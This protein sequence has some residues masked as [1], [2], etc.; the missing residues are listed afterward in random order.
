ME[1]LKES[2]EQTKSMLEQA[3]SNED[4]EVECVYN[5]NFISKINYD[6]VNNYLRK[7]KAYKLIDSNKSS[8]DISLL[9]T[10]YR[11]TVSDKESITE[12]CENNILHF[13]E[14]QKKAKLSAFVPVINKEYDFSIKIKRE[15]SV[16][17]SEIPDFDS[18]FTNRYKHY[19]LK[20]RDSFVD[21]S[22]T[23][24]IDLTV[25]KQSTKV[26]QTI[27]TSG[28]EH[29][30]EKYEI[31][32]EFLNNSNNSK[33]TKTDD[34]TLQL[35]YH[36][37][38]IKK[39]MEDSEYL[40][41]K[42]NKLIVLNKYINLV[43]PTMFDNHQEDII[44]HIRKVVLKRPKEHMLSYQPITLEQM[45]I[46]EE[47]LGRKSIL[48]NYTVTEK[49]DGERYLIF[50][51]DKHDMFSIDSRLSVKKL[52]VKH[53]LKNILVDAEFVVKSKFNTLLETFYC[54]DIYFNNGD[55]VRD[56]V[57]VPDRVNLMESFVKH[58]P[59]GV[60]VEMKKFVQDE[61]IF[62][63]CAKVYNKS[64]YDY[65]IDGLIFTPSNLVVGGVYNKELA[66][67][68]TFGGPW[69]N[70]FK[71]KPPDENSIDFL[72]RYDNQIYLK[73]FGKCVLC[74]LQVAMR[75]YSDEFI[76][77]YTILTTQGVYER[78]KMAPKTFAEV[79]LKI[80]DKGKHPLTLNNEV[81]YDNTIIEFIYD[82]DE[83]E[84]FCWIPYRIRSDKTQIYKRSGSIANTANSYM[85]ALNVW[86]SIQNPV[87]TDM[88]IGKDKL[89]S[90][91]INKNNVYYSRNINREKILSKPM[92]T[93]H[94]TGV[95]SKLFSLFKN[96]NYTLCDLASGKAGDLYKWIDT[97]FA[98]VVGIDNNID[99]ILNNVDGAYRRLTS[100][101]NNLKHGRKPEIIF[102]QKDLKTDWD[103]VSSIENKQMMELY[104]TMWGN[105]YK[106]EV[107]NPS[108]LKY[109]N[110]MNKKF[111]VVSCQFAIHYMFE[112][113]DILETF[114]SNIE[115]IT[116]KDGYF[117]GT[118]LDGELVDKM[119]NKTTNGMKKGIYND[120]T[121]WMVEKKY[122]TF[123][124]RTGQ[125]INVYL[126][127]INV[128]HEEYLVHFD[129]LIEKL[130]EKGFKLL[131]KNDL[132][133]MK[134]ET[135]MGSFEELHD[136]E[137]F[138][139]I[140]VLKEYSYLNKW[141]IF[142]KY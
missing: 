72:V 101:K 36:I 9:D 3:K 5:S 59:K 104:N 116:K 100:L 20:Q 50:V 27:K 92:L 33:S 63:A 105:V 112:N 103:D 78:T 19:R 74:K 107:S 31:E 85:T 121:L 26:S 126:E 96:Q 88:I 15:E 37:E 69:M 115:R 118:C 65:N 12:L 133:K 29:A 81:I 93:F 49:A 53:K 17:V 90:A 60:N 80:T 84:M 16:K 2:F 114:C 1:I 38:N 28:I 7:S 94:N 120:N 32:I 123:E 117:I 41:S 139:M 10:D 89:T 113:N 39:I 108:I 67:K 99:N 102:L 132:A 56:L 66:T 8:L 135:S 25:V 131:A 57:L 73:D 58:V 54:F 22:E 134:L 45:N 97:R 136:N 87:T 30:V 130:S 129:L 127:S 46:V 109:F 23:F 55:D 13:F 95:K 106:N 44:E 6:R 111:D 47:E 79:Y 124:K 4:Y 42:E 24:R 137:E 11:I 35:Y 110:Y 142:K 21:K 77:P 48:K 86:R 43:N 70:V 51:D 82:E 75:A 18:E 138:P 40:L 34:L 98:Y 76:D 14:V 71:W 125:S 61:N 64:K 68:N 128:V 91:D 52:G 119:L 141:F 83:S 62:K 140:D 122:S